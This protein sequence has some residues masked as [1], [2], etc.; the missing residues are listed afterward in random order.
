MHLSKILINGFKSF[1]DSIE[2]E[3]DQGITGVVGPNGSGKSN[4]IDAVRWVMGEQNAKTLRGEKGTDIIFAGSQSRK[5]LGMAEVSLVFDNED[6]SAFCPA[7][8]QHESEITLTRRIYQ[9]GQRDYLINRKPCRLKDIVNFFAATGLGGKSYSMIQQGQVDRILNSKPEGV[10]EIIEE[11]A[12]TTIFKK[13]KAE[14]HRRLS[15]THEN[16]E[17]IDDILRELIKQKKNLKRQAEKAKEHKQH[18]DDLKEKETTLFS[19]GYYK[20]LDKKN[21]IHERLEKLDSK[22]GTIAESLLNLDGKLSEIQEQLDEADPEVQA[23]QE[24]IT[25]TREQIVRSENIIADAEKFHQSGG[26]RNEEL[27][28]L[29]AEESKNLEEFQAQLDAAQ[30]EVDS[31]KSDAQEFEKKLESVSAEL[32]RFENSK[33]SYSSELENFEDEIKNIERLIASN[34]LRIENNLQNKEDLQS[35]KKNNQGRLRDLEQEYGEILILLEAAQVKVA[36]ERKGIDSKLLQKQTIVE[37]T[38]VNDDKL[39]ELGEQRDDLKQKY[40]ECKT[41]ISSLKE[42]ADENCDVFGLWEQL[43]DGA[44]KRLILLANSLKISEAGKNLSQN[45]QKAIGYFLESI[46][47]S[48]GSYNELLELARNQSCA[49][50]KIFNEVKVEMDKISEW[51]ERFDLESINSYVQDESDNADMAD[52]LRRVYVSHDIQIDDQMVLDMPSGAIIISANGCVYTDPSY[53]VVIS[54]N[55]SSVLDKHQAIADLE[56]QLKSDEENLAAV[57]ME[58]DHFKT[59]NIENRDSLKSIDHFLQSQ[60][61]DCLLYTSPSPRDRTRSRMPS[62]A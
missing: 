59:Q 29:I 61:K 21:S 49:N 39:Q 54:G 37:S 50:F 7:E 38:K 20:N 42:L 47:C 30:A 13:K 8:Y 51:Q 15:H 16:L 46:Y 40:I 2:V 6:S 5:Q 1:A 10:R 3:V 11:A 62:S 4:I 31:A 60:N 14:A 43:D 27:D 52:I 44:K 17:R 35:D 24:Q 58:F 25:I 12:G 28:R 57:Q 33:S 19:F 48:G 36:S 9:D 26:S 55:E 53:C 56:A 34:E 22:Q 41:K 18:I 23:M 45:C 32:E